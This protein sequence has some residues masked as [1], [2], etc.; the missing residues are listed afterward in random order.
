[1][2][3]MRGGL[4][5][6][7]GTSEESAARMT[8][9]F[10]TI[11]VGAGIAAAGFVGLLVLNR[12]TVAAEE[13]GTAIAEVS[14]LVDEATFS[15]AEMEK[16]TRALAL[17]FGGKAPVQAKALYQI[18]SAGA[19]NAEE[20]T[21]LLTQTNKLALGG[22]TDLTTAADGLTTAMNVYAAQ[23]LSA[24]E[25][26]DALFVA[27]K[28]GK[29]TIGELSEAMG[30]VLPTAGAL[31][32]SFEE[33]LAAISAVTLGGLKTREA[34][35]GLKAALAGVQKP[36]SEAGKEAKRLG[37]QFDAATL[38]A[39]GLNKFM[40]DIMESSGFTADSFTQLFGS[41]E[42]LNAITALATNE[43][44]KFNEMIAAMGQKTGATDAAVDKM[45]GTME[46]ARKRFASARADM[47]LTIG[48]AIEPFKTAILDAGSRIFEVFTALPEPV[49]KFGVILLGLASASAVVVGG[50]IA[51][52]GAIAALGVIGI[53]ALAPLLIVAA[54]VLLVIGLLVAAALVLK[55]AWETNF[56][57]I[58][59][60][61]AGFVE[62]LRSLWG[63]IVD[64]LR[65]AWDEFIGAITVMKDR[66]V[67]ILEMFG[68]F[69][70]KTEATGSG[71]QKFGKILFGIF[72]FGFRVAAVFVRV[73]LWV[74]TK[75]IKILTPIFEMFAAI[76]GTIA[77]V[78]G[79]IGRFLG[80]GGGP[81]AGPEIV[82]GEFKRRP[83]PEAP[84][85]PGVAPLSAAGALRQLATAERAPETPA[86]ARP[87][88]QEFHTQV[89]I[90]GERVVD[91]VDR[92][93]ADDD[94]RGGRL[95]PAFAR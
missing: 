85:A 84:G 58:R 41:I 61:V 4:D 39:K 86:P 29:T 70:D 67:G 66:I 1:M 30:R 69:G 42:G 72:T 88:V 59:N 24:Q 77:Q 18:I 9:A 12:T 78:G 79:V 82:V 50:I 36:T 92:R 43:G 19:S 54:K 32:I 14:T 33:M 22:V 11:G 94:L 83:A 48:K 74:Q 95:K 68:L 65:P 90:D 31:G 75:I 57:G 76:A 6:L 26:S 87:G 37:I 93:R 46:F 89:N 91:A 45:S 27:M 71:L 44:A 73:W 21:A 15:T 8:K 62:G 52:K 81:A 53:V 7:S 13:F 38:R 51:I 28:G 64:M 5:S 80:L 56:L 3:R 47:V 40:R 35:T 60:V 2:R 49:K 17:Q 10:K 23:G 20:A 34:V 16:I 55:K 63:F 25:A